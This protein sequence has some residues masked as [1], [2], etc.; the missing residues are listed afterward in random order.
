MLAISLAL[1]LLSQASAASP[2]NAQAWAWD[3]KAPICTL[4]QQHAPGTSAVTIERTPGDEE[5]ELL[6]ALPR[7]PKPGTGHF[8][9]AKIVTDTGRTFTADITM[10]DKNELYVDSP[11][12]ALIDSLSGAKWLDISHPKIRPVRVE[13]SIPSEVVKL[14][15]VCEDQTMQD[16]GIDPIGWRGLKARPMPLEHVRERFSA[17]DY[18][19]DALAANVEA[20]AV[21]RLDIGT[22]GAVIKCAAVNPGLPHT[23]FESASC[24]VLRGAKFRPAVDANGRPTS[25]P[26]VYDVRFRIGS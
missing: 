22:D 6:I 16:W 12:P 4:K 10:G 13:I 21:T 18:P 26:V 25:A 3:D 19:T 2:A 20:D 1:V 9:D 15:R 5:T 17:L 24:R 7:G 8:L 11:D 14:L 23:S